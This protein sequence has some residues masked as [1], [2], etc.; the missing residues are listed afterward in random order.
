[1]IWSL[2]QMLS[3]VV[4]NSQIVFAMIDLPDSVFVKDM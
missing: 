2:L 3:A 1:M 4:S